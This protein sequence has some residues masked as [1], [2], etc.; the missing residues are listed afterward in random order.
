GFPQ[1]EQ[2]QQV[3][4]KG[5]SVHVR[6]IGS[7]E[8]RLEY[9]NHTSARSRKKALLEKVVSDVTQGRALVFPKRSWGKIPGLQVSP[10]GVI[11]EPTKV[12][13]IHDLSY[14]QGS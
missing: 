6:G 10:V 13:I 14:Q 3:V 1:I 12:R 9:G 8:E 4:N 5:V 2:L 7:V 11:Q